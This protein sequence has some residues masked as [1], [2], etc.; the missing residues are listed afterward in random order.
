MKS[1]K[2]REEQSRG[3]IVFHRKKREPDRLNNKIFDARIKDSDYIRISIIRE[4]VDLHD[5]T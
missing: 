5:V 4:G 2:I 1:I 3:K